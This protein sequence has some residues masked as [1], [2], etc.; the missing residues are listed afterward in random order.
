MA[1]Q[2]TLETLRSL[3]DREHG[4]IRQEILAERRLVEQRFEAID[5]ATH[6]ETNELARRLSELNHAHELARQKEVD[7]VGR[8][9]TGRRYL[10]FAYA[11]ISMLR[12]F[13]ARCTDLQPDARR[14]ALARRCPRRFTSAANCLSDMSKKWRRRPSSRKLESSRR[15]PPPRL[16]KRL[17]VIKMATGTARTS[18]AR[19][20]R[21]G[22]SFEAFEKL[23]GRKFDPRGDGRLAVCDPLQALAAVR[24]GRLAQATWET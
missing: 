11:V 8:E 1:E 10:L 24:L 12:S 16:R 20:A 23:V 21:R 15:Q 2:W 19:R 14:R 22:K 17:G 6:I 4:F 13:R 18:G 9:G 3:M 5:S 7:F